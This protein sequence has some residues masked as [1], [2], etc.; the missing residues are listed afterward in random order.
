MIARRMCRYS[1]SRA[2]F[3]ECKHRI[4]RPTRLERADVLKI[5]ALKKQ[6][7][8]RRFIQPLAR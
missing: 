6:L 4:C 5:F 2:R 7:H 8:P 3:I 1:T